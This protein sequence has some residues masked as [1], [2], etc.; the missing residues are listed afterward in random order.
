MV[1]SSAPDNG[2]VFSLPQ[3]RL[4]RRL[5]LAWYGR[6]KRDLPWR[7]RE[8]D[9]YAQLVAEFMLQQ[10]QVAKVVDY[11]GRFL[12]R[13]PTVAALAAADR[14]EVLRIW[15]GLG[16][17]SRA[18]NLHA[19]ARQIVEEHGG[20][21]PASVDELMALPGIGRYTA[22]A[23]ASVAYGVRAAVL[24][25]N[26]VRVLLRLL[27]SRM[28]PSAPATRRHLWSVAESLLPR[29]HTGQFNQALMELGA[30][31]CT[32]RNPGCDECPLASCCR[33][34]AEGMTN[35]I[36]LPAKRTTVQSVVMVVAAVRQGGKLLFVRRPSSGLWAGLWE[37]PSEAM[38]AGE[39]ET[40]ARGRLRQRLPGGTR[41]STIVSGRVVRQLT[42]RTITFHIYEG[43]LSAAAT[44]AGFD[45]QPSRWVGPDQRRSLGMSRA[46]QAILRT[47]DRP[48]RTNE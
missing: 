44:N 37:L 5:L 2:D 25:G 4:I 47:L 19:A 11:Y 12:K 32:P 42:H 18:R 45:G 3:R 7:R 30:T 36:P 31:V 29:K 1:R 39:E 27:G 9:A 41:L 48:T 38:A 35:R 28:D 21:V 6:R 26:V 17:Y 33:A 20:M 16:Y 15:A 46:C 40:I 34:R 22:G 24:D 8:K 23:I 10:T 13:F 14:D 43:T